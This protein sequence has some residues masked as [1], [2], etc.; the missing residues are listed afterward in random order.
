[1]LLF[2][3]HLKFSKHGIS[4]II[5]ITDFIPLGKSLTQWLYCAISRSQMCTEAI[6][7]FDY[8]INQTLQR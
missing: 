4:S 1:M 5:V 3:L 7:Q 2:T 8:G 6:F